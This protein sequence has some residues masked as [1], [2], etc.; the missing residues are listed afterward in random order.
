MTFDDFS[1][2][3]VGTPI[4]DATGA[5]L[6]TLAEIL[7][8]GSTTTPRFAVIDLTADGTLV[9]VP[10]QALG[11]RPGDRLALDITSDALFAAP[12]VDGRDS[13]RVAAARWGRPEPIAPVRLEPTHYGRGLAVGLLVLVLVGAVGFMAAR[14]S[15][16][17]TSA[18]AQRVTEVMKS[19]AV[20][21]KQ[22]SVD[23]AT[24]M[25]VKTA[26]ALS[27]RVPALDVNVE[28]DHSVTTLTGHVP[29]PETRDIAGDIAADT[30]GVR[31]VRNLL[32]VEPSNTP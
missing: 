15:S 3:R 4:V 32:T 6:G 14:R 30:A 31:E 26:L 29:S 9:I 10:W 24:T 20:V 13:R 16:P 2:P 7:Y 23:T 27:K 1:S 22:T 28:T 21:V 25:K 18:Q 17:Q 5:Q 11:I 19:T 8:E 12:R